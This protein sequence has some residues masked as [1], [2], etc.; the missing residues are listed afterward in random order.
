MR[1]V[2]AKLLFIVALCLA[3][4]LVATVVLSRA[5]DMEQ[6][7]ERASG[8]RAAQ[9]RLAAELDDQIEELEL[10]IRLLGCDRDV[11]AEVAAG[12]RDDIFEHLSHFSSVYGGL[13]VY[14]ADAN[15]ELVASS[16]DPSL[17]GSLLEKLPGIRAALDGS[18]DLVKIGT[19]QL[20][21][22]DR[23]YGFV[24]TGPVRVGAEDKP[25]GA[26]V[27]AFR[28]NQ[29]FWKSSAEKVGLELSL[30][31]RDRLVV[32]TDAA[33]DPLKNVPLNKPVA[34]R[35][36]DRVMVTTAF[37]L[38]PLRN[39]RVEASV[40][41]TD[42]V[43]ADHRFLLYRIVTLLVVAT[44][45]VLVAL[46]VASRMHNSVERLSQ[47]LPDFALRKYTPVE[48]IRTG[49][50]IQQLSEAYNAVVAQL[51][52]GEHFRKALGKYLSRAALEQIKKG[53][54][55][56]GGS[57]LP[58]TVLFS[59]IRGF[60]TLAEKM[61]PVQLL[62]VLNRYFTEMVAAVMTH[63]GIVDKFIGDAIMAVWGPPMTQSNRTDALNAVRAAIDMRAR[64]SRLNVELAREGLPLL[65]T[66]VGIHSGQV[67]AGN[68]GAEETEQL[69][70][71]MEYTVIGDTVNLASRLESL[72]KELK[73]D[74]ILSEDTYLLIRDEFE[75]EA[76]E[77]VK[78]RGRDRAVQVYRLVGVAMRA[79]V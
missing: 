12:R 50:E 4:M 7:S 19:T 8:L 46:R 23:H 26:V 14:V 38:A 74:V 13:V 34:R 30:F 11:V 32:R 76:I 47:A 55:A 25:V 45:A 27:A 22:E 58:A 21:F 79:A 75:C 49:D 37:E 54:L 43:K 36:G 70:G 39:A 28:L 48:V 73:S 71:K 1:T 64:L 24:L 35:I 6:Q 5:L 33:P 18:E 17:R 16:A 20:P 68:M 29:E 56:L 67:V 62:H 9:A 60:T 65:Q 72:T 15:G 2:R 57:V 53:E 66:G 10:A 59:D 44:I 77:Q 31:V 40:D 63:E 3:P 41:I 51:T 42:D 61:D 78:V 52:E 69:A